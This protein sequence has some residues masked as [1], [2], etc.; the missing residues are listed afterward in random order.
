MVLLPND[1]VEPPEALV[2]T[3][4]HAVRKYY[5]DLF[6]E[7]SRAEHRDVKAVIVGMA[8]AGKTR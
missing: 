8:G 2:A 6:A 1:F 4:I 7:G 3:G 5:T